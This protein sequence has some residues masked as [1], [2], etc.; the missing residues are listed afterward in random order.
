MITILHLDDSSPLLEDIRDYL[1]VYGFTVISCSNVDAAKDFLD[2][3]PMPDFGIIDLFLD[4]AGGAHL[5]NDFI[6][7]YLIPNDIAYIRLTSAPREVPREF[8]GRGIM[9]KK[10]FYDN[11][12]K[13]V[14]IINSLVP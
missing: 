1:E 14:E 3:S 6:R 10:D 2:Q 4:G 7:D 9:H 11:P 13:L 12:N 5:S 8:S